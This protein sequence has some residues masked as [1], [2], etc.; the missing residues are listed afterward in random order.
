[1]S[2]QI[3]YSD[4]FSKHDNQGHPE[5]A[6]RLQ[7][8]IDEIK[9]SKFYDKLEFIKPEILAEDKLF[10]IHSEEMIEQIKEISSF[11]DSCC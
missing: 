7:V 3:V 11:G 5:N 9:N 10:F 4:D 8:M 2:T 6:K 1:M